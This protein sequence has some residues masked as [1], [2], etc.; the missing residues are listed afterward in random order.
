MKFDAE[1]ATQDYINSLGNQALEK[2]AAYTSG[3]HWLMLGGLL[4]TVFVTW[5][6][7]RSGLLHRIAA[8]LS[9]RGFFLR[10]F[11]ICAGFLVLSGIIELPWSIYTGWWRETLYGRTSQSLADFLGQSG[12]ALALNTLFMGL[13]LTAVYGLIQ[14][15][16]SRWWLWSGSLTAG[17]IALLLLLGPIAIEPL[18]NDY[19][20]VPEGE[21][22]DAVEAM[23]IEA[24]IPTDSIF[25]YDGSRQ[26]NNFTANVSGIG[27]SA[28]I[29][30]SD[31]ALDAA[32]LDEVKAVTGHEVGHYVLGH[33]WDIVAVLTVLVMVSFLLADRLFNPIARFFGAEEDV[34]NP[35]SLPVLIFIVGLLMTLTQPITNTLSRS[36]E[37]EADRY[38]LE[39]VNL[40]DAL[41]SSLV[42]TAEYRYPR[43]T[44]L[45]EWLFYTHPSV[46]R[47]VRRAMEWKAEHGAE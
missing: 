3:N 9:N 2:A 27:S 16:G 24:G 43:P 31:V 33:V 39:S 12:L 45:Q 6:I 44:Q 11:S 40:P 19:K 42:Q 23:A 38:S 17:S 34:S 15:V 4:V 22:K 20:T 26:S 37:T 41:A 10:T 8:T 5:L 47:R 29:A 13:F 1:Q 7:V 21:V 18:F 35:A 46:E 32:T 28:R 14:R 30:I 36:N 25:M